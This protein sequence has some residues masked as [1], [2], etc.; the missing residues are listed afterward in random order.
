MKT[1]KKLLLFF[2]ILLLTG[3]S[4][5]IYST[6]AEVMN[7][8]QNSLRIRITSSKP[9]FVLGELVSFEIEIT[10]ES[11]ES[12]LVRGLDVDSNYVKIFVA[13]AGKKFKEYKHSRVKETRW[14]KFQPRQIVKSNVN[15]LW[16]FTPAKFASNPSKF[17]GTNIITDYVF[18]KS[19][20]YFIKAVLVIPNSNETLNI[21][22]ETIQLNLR[23]PLGEDQEVWNKIKNNGDFGYFLQEGDFRIPEY[24]QEER[25]MFKQEVE[26]IVNR[27]PNSFITGQLRQSIEKF[28]QKEAKRRELREKMKQPNRPQ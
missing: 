26:Q 17:N 4:S 23:D 15:I 16:N 6:K 14:M 5:L 24:K 8:P 20:I 25:I 19:G 1:N 9:T 2:G 13:E 27:H 28:N 7:L 22:S 3:L 10:N 11:S 18:P 21:E 12:V